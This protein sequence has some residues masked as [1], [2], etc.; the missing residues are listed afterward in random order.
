MCLPATKKWGQVIRSAAP[1]TQ[2]HLSK[3][4]DLMLQN[5]TPLRKSP[6]RSPN[7]SN[8]CVSCT[9]LP[10]ET[11]LSRSSSNVPRLPSFLKLLK[12]TARFAHF[13]PGARKTTSER[14]KVLCTP[15]FS[16][17]LTSKCASRYNGVRFF[18]IWTSKSAPRPSA[19]TLLTLKCASRH[20]GVHFFDMSTSKSG[21][22][23]VCF[24]HFGLDMCF[25][26]Q[27]RAIFNRSAPAALASLLFNPPEPRINGKTQCFATFRP[28][29][30]PGSSF[31]WL[32]LLWSSFFFS[33]LLFWLSLLWSSFFFSSLTLPMS[34]FHLSILSEVWLL[35]FLRLWLSISW[36]LAIFLFPI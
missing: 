6:P 28:F 5:A 1:V 2:N 25:L 19:F 33:A 15:Q 13:W 34:A 36:C 30:A 31:F 7:T 11:H 18:D 21:P 29:R 10:R 22:R 9:A 17:L 14:P 24:V 35:N 4:E 32:S 27:R 26:R 16:A 3:P 8:S 12:K 23:M 20:N